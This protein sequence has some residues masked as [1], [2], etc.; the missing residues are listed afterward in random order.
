MSSDH[1]SQPGTESVVVV[2]SDGSDGGEGKG[3]CFALG[4]TEGVSDDN[5]CPG[6][7][8][9]GKESKQCD[10][11][12]ELALDSPS[13]PTLAKRLSRVEGVGDR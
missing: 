3:G 9:E 10:S 6:G 11:R 1:H 7:D 4:G 12:R 8:C 2:K 5:C 13:G